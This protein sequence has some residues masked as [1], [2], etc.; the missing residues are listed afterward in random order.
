MYN[1]SFSLS[2]AE[3]VLLIVGG[4]VS[5]LTKKQTPF[6][7]FLWSGRRD[8]EKHSLNQLS[9]IRHTTF[10]YKIKISH[11]PSTST[12]PNETL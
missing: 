11:F 6:N 1:K 2:N 12:V 3:N 7:L 5:L 10:T 8:I 4:N 9:P